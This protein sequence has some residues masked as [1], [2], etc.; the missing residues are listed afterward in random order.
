MAVHCK[1]SLFWLWALLTNQMWQMYVRLRQRL[2]LKN[3]ASAA[4][5]LLGMMM[6]LVPGTSR[7]VSWFRRL[8]V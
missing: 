1:V 8:F 2:S 4:Q 3:F 7:P 5:L 6:S